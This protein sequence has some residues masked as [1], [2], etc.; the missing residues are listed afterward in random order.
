MLAILCAGAA[1]A[2]C[3]STGTTKTASLATSTL[4]PSTLASNGSTEAYPMLPEEILTIPVSEAAAGQSEA[5]GFA[6]ASVL[7]PAAL[8][9]TAM[10]APATDPAAGVVQVS[11]GA[12]Q[13]AQGRTLPQTALR[14][15][16]GQ[17]LPVSRDIANAEAGTVAVQPAVMLA[18]AGDPQYLAA[19]PA[20]FAGNS[21]S[22]V[23]LATTAI[24]PQPA[25]VGGVINA[26]DGRIGPDHVEARSAELDN[27]IARYANYYKVP[28]AL[29]RRTINRES[30]FNPAARN[31]K[32]LG[33]MQISHRTAVGMGY[34]GPASGLFDAETNLKYAVRYLRGAWLVARGDHAR[35]DRLYQT[36][37]YYDAKREGLLDETGLGTDR[38]RRSHSMPSQTEMNALPIAS[39]QELSAGQL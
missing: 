12:A 6:A 16:A 22:R 14:T 36:G 26:P 13:G 29:V 1:V 23:Q 10:A 21:P 34:R 18:S 24:D 33:L 2:A 32:Y 37:Y 20:A 35:A 7:K 27:L 17:Q 39:Q 30:T 25:T 4:A 5:S 9:V 31:G 15:T 3:T 11:N 28:L 19:Q 38:R 8:Q